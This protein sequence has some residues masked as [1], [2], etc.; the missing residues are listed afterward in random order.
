MMPIRSPPL[1]LN[2]VL[3]HAQ[4]AAGFGVASTTVYRYVVEALVATSLQSEIRWMA[5]SPDQ[6]QK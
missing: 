6:P 3:R 2:V 1:S 4:L 5:Q